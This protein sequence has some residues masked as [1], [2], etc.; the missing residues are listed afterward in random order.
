M[1]K[2]KT[3]WKH[4]HKN[5][6]KIKIHENRWLIW[7]I[8][9]AVFISAALIA[10][11][12]ISEIHF[13]NQMNQII[14]SSSWVSFRNNSEG[15]TL[16]YPRTWGVESEGNSTMSF[17]NLEDVGAYFTVTT[18]PISEEKEV[19]SSLSGTNE[20]Q[21]KI[22]GLNG[23]KLTL[24]G[25]EKVVILKDN[26]SLYVLRGKGIFFERIAGTFKLN[27]KLERI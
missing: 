4:L 26:Q 23:V 18:Y 24:S 17:V 3:N 12:Q 10:H 11:I 9:L 20:E 22:D 13:E 27:Q 25:N 7:T 15:Y 1:A 8:S 14:S 19:R 2:A 21:V 16:K 6:H 5:L